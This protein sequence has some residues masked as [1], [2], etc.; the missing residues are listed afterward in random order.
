VSG[1][2][3]AAR[4]SRPSI[5]LEKAPML[6]PKHNRF[7][8][9]LKADIHAGVEQAGMGELP[10]PQALLPSANRLRKLSNHQS[11]LIVAVVDGP[12]RDVL[13]KLHASNGAFV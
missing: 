3:P 5:D 9:Q 4:G 11:L 6:D 12:L 7:F 2:Q 13:Y 8:E 10:A 1:A